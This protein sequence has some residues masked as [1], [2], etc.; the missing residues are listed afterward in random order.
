MDLSLPYIFTYHI[1][2]IYILFLRAVT[3]DVGSTPTFSP[4]AELEFPTSLR[5]P[6][7]NKGKE[8]SAEH[9]G[10]IHGLN[11]TNTLYTAHGFD[12]HTL[13]SQPYDDCCYSLVHY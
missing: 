11:I 12:I 9:T 5:I 8:G 1:I 6:G 4:T 2:P 13:L 10:M 3:G 7:V